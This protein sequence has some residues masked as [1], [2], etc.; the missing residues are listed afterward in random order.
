MGMKIHL[1]IRILFG[2]ILVAAGIFKLVS[3]QAPPRISEAGI[4]FINSLI[5]TGYMF[6]FVGVIEIMSGISFLFNK[7]TTLGSLIL[8]PITTNY[9]LFHIF[10]DFKSIIGALVFFILNLYMIYSNID[11]IKHVLV[12]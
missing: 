2:L 12:K 8:L 4:L 10:L 1:V 5:T 6:V 9:I 7:Y 3:P 11:K